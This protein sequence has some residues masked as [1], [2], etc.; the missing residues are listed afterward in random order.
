MAGGRAEKTSMRKST[1]TAFALAVA[2]IAVSAITVLAES[3]L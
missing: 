3:L 1:S 2:L